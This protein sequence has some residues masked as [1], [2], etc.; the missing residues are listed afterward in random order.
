VKGNASRFINHSCAP[1]CETQKWRVNGK[2]RI[3]IFAL[4]DIIAGEEVTFDYKCE[5]FGA[6]PQAY[7]MSQAIVLCIVPYSRSLMI[8]SDVYVVRSNVVVSLVP[9]QRSLRRMVMMKMMMINHRSSVIERIVIKD[10]LSKRLT[11]IVN[12]LNILE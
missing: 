9:N 5:R 3:G 1:V 10:P 12:S 7:V 4:K 8:S 11:T 2:F 6:K